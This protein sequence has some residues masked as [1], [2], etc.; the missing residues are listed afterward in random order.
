MRKLLFL[1]SICLIITSC[2]TPVKL[3]KRS[4]DFYLNNKPK[5]AELCLDC[6]GNKSDTVYKK[7]DLI[8]KIDTVL[9]S[10]PYVVTVDC[11]DGTKAKADCPPNKT[12]I[13]D[14]SRIDTAFFD[15]W[16]TTAQLVFLKDYKNNADK[17]NM[18]LSAKIAALEGEIKKKDK[19][20]MVQSTVIW[21]ISLGI[22]LFFGIKILRLFKVF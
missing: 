11:P 3:E 13:I 9:D 2:M 16:Q 17:K 20:I 6:F 21:I 14:N 10:V 22:G 8:T 12:I 4:K 15:T 1:L 19:E 7:G 5:L 18:E